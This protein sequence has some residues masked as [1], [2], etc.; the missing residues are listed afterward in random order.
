VPIVHL[1][2]GVP[3]LDEV[4]GGGLP[5][6]SF[7]IIAGAPGTGKTTL[8]Q[9]ILFANASRGRPATYFTIF[10]EPPLKL[11]RYQQQFSFFDIEKVNR[12]IH[13]VNLG[14]QA[15]QGDLRAVFDT[16]VGEVRDRNAS[17][18]AI[19]SFRGTPHNEE[20]P[21]PTGAELQRFAHQLALYLANA[22]A[23]SF[24]IGE[25]QPLERATNPLFTTADGV[26][27]L[28]QVVDGHQPARKLEVLKMR[29][30]GPRPGLHGVRITADGVQIM[31]SPTISTPAPLHG[32]GR[33]R[34][35]T[36]V[37]ELDRMLGGGIPAGDA[38]LVEGVSGTGK[39]ILAT[40][41]I[42]EGGQAGE[43][44]VIVLAEEH[45]ERFVARAQALGF[46]LLPL[47]DTHIVEIVSLR[48]P[49]LSADEVLSHIQHTVRRLG[50]RRLAIDSLAGL[51]LAVA[52][53]VTL[54][55]WL[56]Q[57]LE[58]LT[59]TGVTVCVTAGP[60]QLDGS[61]LPTFLF[62]DVVALRQVE[63][64]GRLARLLAIVKMRASSHSDE[65]RLYEIDS[66]GFRMGGKL[67]AIDPPVDPF[68]RPK[69]SD[70]QKRANA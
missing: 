59:S 39:S 7:N 33:E 49:D 52:S 3:G 54:R 46:G 32:A 1:P 29:G 15:L 53:S 11:L 45:P 17:L 28:R 34:L 27:W 12:T 41:F 38:L 55:D 56:Y 63:R 61:P 4:L 16:I 51:E 6:F 21:E 70:V 36:G 58:P 42:A 31:P 65:L 66:R 62:D 22:Q 2:T 57:A 18:V 64:N 19:D 48:R 13:F 35:S 50:A 69:L 14:Q 23:T 9:Q 40:Q 47:L 25:Y 24:L 67:D 10:G 68:G 26:F 44:G 60:A 8:T 37:E 5:E 43:P 20:L 30:Q